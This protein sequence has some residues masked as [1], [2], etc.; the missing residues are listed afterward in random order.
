[1]DPDRI[2]V[3][4]SPKHAIAHD[5][6]SRSSL[7]KKLYQT[8]RV[9]E[10]LASDRMTGAPSTSKSGGHQSSQNSESEK[11]Y[12]PEAPPKEAAPSTPQETP[13]FV[14]QSGLVLW[15]RIK[16]RLFAP[17]PG[18]SP[19]RQKVMVISI[20]ILVIV[21]IFAFRQ[22]LN[23]SPRKAKGVP[24]EDVALVVEAD[25]GHEIDWQIPEPLPA[26]MRDPTV[27]PPVQDN[28]QTEEQ[29]QPVPMPK[30]K[31][32]DLGS[33]VYSHDRPSAI[34]NGRIVHVGEQVSGVTILKIDRDSVEFEKDGERW[35][36]KMRD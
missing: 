31:R 4:D 23:Q 30:R 29:K 22:V 1:V 33:I 20:P 15:Q 10:M 6:A 21:S 25:S 2:D 5:P 27:L 35:I 17:K 9:P 28:T 12:G 24:A 3:G 34:V 26:T 11:R 19:A 32:V 36:Q 16:D 13:V 14:E 7:A 8:E 18:I